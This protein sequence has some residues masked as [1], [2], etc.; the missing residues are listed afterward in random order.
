MQ[1]LLQEIIF[2]V[3]SQQRSLSRELTTTTKRQ[4]DVAVLSSRYNNRHD[5]PTSLNR[6]ASK[7]FSSTVG[8]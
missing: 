4:Q 1:Q 6:D 2:E 7:F 8:F 5:L 3:F